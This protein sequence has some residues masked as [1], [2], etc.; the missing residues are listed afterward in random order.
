MAKR[1]TK[2]KIR[3]VTTLVVV[4]LL[5][6]ST[7]AGTFLVGATAAGGELFGIHVMDTET[8]RQIVDFLLEHKLADRK[9]LTFFAN[10]F[11]STQTAPPVSG[12]EVQFHFIDVGQADAALI[13][14]A[15]GNVLI[16]AGMGASEEQLKAYLDSLGVKDIAYAVFT[17][18]HEDH[19]GGADMILAEYNVQKVILPDKEANTVVFEKM[20]D[21]IE[22][23]GCEV[24]KAV[25]DMNFKVGEVSFTVLAPISKDYTDLN[26]Y[27]V[28]IRAEYGETS[29]LFT[30]D[31]E[32]VSEKEM[33]DRYLLSGK[34]DCD[35]LK[36]GHHGSDTSSSK[37]FLE[38]VTPVHAVIS[39]GE[40]NTHGHP[41]QEII[42]RYESMSIII[43]RTDLLGSIVFTSTGG[44]PIKQ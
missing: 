33:L 20:M 23:E 25:P 39:V 15:A 26:N 37:A 4:I 44:E 31:A 13:R 35:I 21:G 8:S 17:H 22:A 41:K 18:P 6:F 14:T 30:G 43:Y 38:A 7:L 1:I 5:L 12:D 27:S 24:I 28:V 34:L 32:T 3:I 29:V 11:S 19:I 2:K 10:L 16:D 42:T 40:G 36:S 9:T